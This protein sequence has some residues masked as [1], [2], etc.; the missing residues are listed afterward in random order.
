MLG[1]TV[2]AL[3]VA[4]SLPSSSVVTIIVVIVGLNGVVMGPYLECVAGKKSL[5]FLPHNYLKKKIFQNYLKYGK[6]LI[7]LGVK[8]ED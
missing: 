4:V 2:T 8:N 6:E 5:A 3:D 1:F 7:K